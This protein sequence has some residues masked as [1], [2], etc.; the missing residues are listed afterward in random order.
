MHFPSWH[1][2]LI[3]FWLKNFFLTTLKLFPFVW[4][5]IHWNICDRERILLWCKLYFL[6]KLEIK[7]KLN[8]VAEPSIAKLKKAMNSKRMKYLYNRTQW[9]CENM[10][11]DNWNYNFGM[12]PK[13]DSTLSI[14][15]KNIFIEYLS[16]FS[17]QS[18]NLKMEWI[19]FSFISDTRSLST[20][21]YAHM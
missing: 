6:L 19:N 8:G 15:W 21:Q 9:A 18:P 3:R 5:W 14:F 13:N 10:T 7:S 17:I 11:L 4:K 20:I 2:I 16:R 12:D 1:I